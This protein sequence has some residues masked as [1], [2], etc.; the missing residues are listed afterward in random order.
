M[1]WMGVVFGLACLFLWA[2]YFFPSDPF[3]YLNGIRSVH[4]D[5]SPQSYYY[6]MGLLR[7]E[8]WKSYFLVAWLVKTPIP[9]ILLLAVSVGLFLQSKRKSLVEEAFLIIPAVSFFVFYSIFGKNIG[10]RYL[11]P[12][13]PFLFIFAGRVAAHLTKRTHRMALAGLLVWNAAEYAAIMPDHLSYFNQIAGGSAHSV[14]WLDNSNVDWGQGLIQLRDYLQANQIQDYAFFYFGAGDPA[15]YGIRGRRITDFNFIVQ[16]TY[17]T[18]ILSAHGIPRARS[19][20]DNVFG[21]GPL[22]WLRH[23]KP[24]AIVGHAYYVYEIR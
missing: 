3:F 20:L 1:K 21:N 8:G 13:F 14:E 12:C 9:S 22:N 19:I 2:I 7:Q 4:R 16:P 15:H 11:I 24:L 18:V 23:T 5:H 17:G 10:V 6:L